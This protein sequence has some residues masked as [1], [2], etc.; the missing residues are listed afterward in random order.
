MG[1][2]SPRA[3]PPPSGA[4]RMVDSPFRRPGEPHP[5]AQARQAGARR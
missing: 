5:N 1:D 4:G 2:Y 3:P